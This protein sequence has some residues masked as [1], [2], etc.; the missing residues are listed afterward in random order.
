ML[1][2]R[3]LIG[4]G[5]CALAQTGFAEVK[6][7]KER[8]FT[9]IDADSN[10]DS[11]AIW[12]S[13]ETS[14]RWLVATSKAMHK[15]FVY[16]AQNGYPLS[17]YGNAGDQLGQFQRPNGI[18]VIGDMLLVVERDN[19]RIQALSLPDLS[20][21]FSFGEEQLIKPYGIYARHEKNKVLVYVSDDYNNSASNPKPEPNPDG[22]RKRVKVFELSTATSASEPKFV[23]AFGSHEGEGALDVVESL[24]GDD[25]FDR[26]MI[27]DED[28][29]NGMEVHL[30]D[31]DGKDLGQTLGKGRFQ[32]QPEGIA[33]WSTGE[34]SGYWIF[35][36]QGK[37]ENLYLLYDRESLEYVGTFSGE[38]TLNTDGVAIDLTP[39]ERYPE[40]VFYAIHDD[41]GISAW[42]L[43]DIATALDLH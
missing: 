6:V 33:L 3:L 35:T 12:H 28:E 32:Y 20:P 13:S 24:M 8:F 29:V 2:K 7:V 23:K 1:A 37:Q 25:V 38:R 27:A 31:L 11:I 34:K 18:A 14:D 36:D 30:F 10:V 5:L 4:L 19:H 9:T 40:G 16:D 41:S 15:L 17:E 26:L 39:T 43:A 22:L 21:L 42:S